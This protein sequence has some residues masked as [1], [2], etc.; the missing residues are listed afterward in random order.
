MK[1]EVIMFLSLQLI[2][3]GVK[4]QILAPVK[5][6][7][8]AQKTSAT[9]AVLYL[10]ATVQPGWHVFSVNQK[11]GGPQK[12]DF[13]FSKNADCALIGKVTEPTPIARLDQTF[14][15]EIM[16]FENEVVFQQKIKILRKALDDKGRKNDG[17]SVKGK[18]E[19]MACNESQCL[20]PAEV[21][22]TIPI[23]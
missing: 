18:V 19:F 4:A 14:G 22:F 2:F 23:K 21:K 16:Y 7:Y 17:I 3:I 13:A 12:T 15:I 5:W 8:T 11:S 1:K 6:S 20:P 10:K 9:E